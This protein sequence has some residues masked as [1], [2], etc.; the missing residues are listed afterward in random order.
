M[1]SKITTLFI[2]LSIVGFGQ[3]VPNTT[4]FTLQD[5]ATAVF[6]SAG[7]NSLSSSFSS[8]VSGYFDPTY[9]Q[10]GYAPAN[11]ML[12]FRNYNIA[13]G[14]QSAPTVTTGTAT[15]IGVYGAD[16]PGE[17]T[18]DGGATITERGIYLSINS[19]M[20]AATKYVV[21]GTT[22]SFTKT[23]SDYPCVNGTR[24][25]RAFATNS[26]GTSY[27]A[28]NSFTLTALT[29][30]QINY[31]ISYDAI[32]ITDSAKAVTAA[33]KSYINYG[34]AGGTVGGYVNS[35]KAGTN[36]YPSGTG[37]TCKTSIGYEWTIYESNPDTVWIIHSSGGSHISVTRYVPSITTYTTSST[38]TKPTGIDYIKVECWG[39]GGT[40]GVANGTGARAA[41]G[42]GGTYAA[43]I[44]NVTGNVSY[45]VGGA[46]TASTTAKVDGN[47]T[48]FGAS[49]ATALVAA[50]GGVG[51]AVNTSTGGATATTA[52]TT[53]S[54][55][56]TIYAGG[57]GGA[58]TS[59]SYAGGG[60]GGAGS[61][62]TGGNATNQTAGTGTADNGGNG[63]A[64]TNTTNTRNN[65]NTYGGGGSGGIATTSTNRA[66]GNGAA[67]LIRITY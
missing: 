64:G 52:V 56:T 22:G 29:L 14:S 8:A 12:R 2:L 16:M 60:G 23:V 25:F 47:N 32:S 39:G 42:T 10:N 3:S 57:N 21:S 34:S 31:V 62:G 58:G 48:Y 5:V 27:G 11:S 66:G 65:G 50:N 7:T 13:N 55:G 67:G 24:Y 33:S 43:K 40:G 17:V 41:G 19:D 44:V 6:G 20:S 37:T 45:T 18:S 51:G 30:T 36:Q 59:A 35:L 26:A 61:G 1:K 38:W 28:T 15:N 63:G 4:T 46:S 54:I 9:N 53:G 49:F